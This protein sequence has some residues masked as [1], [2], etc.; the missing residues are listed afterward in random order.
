[1]LGL[2]MAAVMMARERRG[3]Q[4]REERRARYKH[5]QNPSHR[6]TS[7]TSPRAGRRRML[8]LYMRRDTSTQN[9]TAL[10]S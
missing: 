9:V 8:F 3:G 1:M 2:V 7:F 10:T 6:T 5:Q 4:D